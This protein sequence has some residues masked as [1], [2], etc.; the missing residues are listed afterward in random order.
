MRFVSSNASAGSGGGIAR[1]TC[2]AGAFGLGVASWLT[3]TTNASSISGAHLVV[4]SDGIGRSRSS[5][6]GPAAGGGGGRSFKSLVL[7]ANDI[8]TNSSVETSSACFG[9]MLGGKARVRLV[10]FFRR[11][12]QRKSMPKRQSSA[13]LP[14]PAARITRAR[15]DSVSAE[16]SEDDPD[17]SGGEGGGGEGGG[18]KGVGGDGEGGGGTGKRGRL[19]D[20]GEAKVR[21]DTEGARGGRAGGAKDAGCDGDGDDGGGGDGDGGGGD[22]KGGGRDGGDEHWPQT[23]KALGLLSS[24]LPSPL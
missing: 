20:E 22:G 23:R 7:W 14:T 3:G 11:P 1:A 2:V 8:S 24:A 5:R 12:Q 10:G 21:G 17:T 4:G 18:G 6:G 16:R 19:E 13:P 15:L 9:N